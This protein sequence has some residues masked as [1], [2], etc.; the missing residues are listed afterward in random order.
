MDGMLVNCRI[1]PNIQ[2]MGGER[3]C[4]SKVSTTGTQ[5]NVPGQGTNLDY[6]I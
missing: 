5:D 2:Y 1:T 6:L 4:E 3:H